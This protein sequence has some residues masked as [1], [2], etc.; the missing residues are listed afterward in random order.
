MDLISTSGWLYS[1]GFGSWGAGLVWSKDRVWQR[2]EDGYGKEGII[3]R[4]V[5]LI[6]LSCFV[7]N[8]QMYWL[9]MKWFGPFSDPSVGSRILYGSWWKRLA[10]W[11]PERN[12]QFILWNPGSFLSLSCHTYISVYYICKS[13]LF[14]LQIYPESNSFPLLPCYHPYSLSFFTRWL[15]SLQATLSASLCCPTE[16]SQ[17][18]MIILKM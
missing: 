16:F 10:R 17:P 2:G 13:F 6:W 7:V 4:T 12:L 15:H 5:P 3:M 18:R 1:S 9:I 14:Y 11:S 8:V